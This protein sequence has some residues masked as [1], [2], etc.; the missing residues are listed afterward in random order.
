MA[1]AKKDA[2]S[3]AVSKPKVNKKPSKSPATTKEIMEKSAKQVKTDVVINS[4]PVLN[5]LSL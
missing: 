1:K 2:K 5:F 4:C 3:T